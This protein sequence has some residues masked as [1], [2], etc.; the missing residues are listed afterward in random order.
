M[1]G[2]KVYATNAQLKCQSLTPLA[3]VALIKMI[4]FAYCCCKLFLRA[5]FLEGKVSTLL[6]LGK[7]IV[8][9]HPL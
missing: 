6:C 8:Y 2:L 5:A 4:T 1:L 9:G 7:P 3:I